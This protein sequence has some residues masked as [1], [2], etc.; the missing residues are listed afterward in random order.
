MNASPSVNLWLGFGPPYAY[1]TACDTYR[2]SAETT[3][4]VQRSTV[5]R[6]DRAGSMRYDAQSITEH[7][8]CVRES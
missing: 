6:R 4:Q 2:D 1:R 7:A 8:T 3:R 5:K